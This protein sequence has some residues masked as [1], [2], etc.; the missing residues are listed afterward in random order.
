M[1]YLYRVINIKARLNLSLLGKPQK[2]YF[3][4]GAA[5]KGLPHPIELSGKRNFF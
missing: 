1:E 2:S 4:S 5:T 3:F